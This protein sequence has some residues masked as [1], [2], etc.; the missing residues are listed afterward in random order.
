MRAASA[1][2]RPTQTHTQPPTHPT[3]SIPFKP[4]TFTRPFRPAQK[5]PRSAV[6]LLLLAALCSAA[7]ATPKR[8]R[9]TV[10]TS[11]GTASSDAG[12]TGS[13]PVAHH[14][15]GTKSGVVKKF[16]KVHRLS[17]DTAGPTAAD[18]STTI[19]A[20][21]QHHHQHQ[22]HQP[23]PTQLP[24]TTAARLSAA[25]TKT[26]LAATRATAGLTA[27]VPSTASPFRR[28]LRTSG[29]GQRHSA[30]RAPLDSQPQASSSKLAYATN[31]I[32]DTD[33]DD[34]YYS[35]R[36]A[37]FLFKSRVGK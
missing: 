25:T 33:A 36:R 35:R 18:K 21:V 26:T 1:I 8:P 30:A 15:S 14:K 9:Q 32:A 28:V 7:V 23:Q 34:D 17:K 22:Q 20:A 11:T 13:P 10:S 16:V 37:R 6:V 5:L 24:L 19:A 29:A 12:P 2:V 3:H 4:L 31:Q 27:V